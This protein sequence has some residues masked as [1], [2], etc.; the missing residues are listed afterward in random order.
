MP[1]ITPGI[2]GVDQLR[3][4][5]GSPTADP[6]EAAAVSDEELK[7]LIERKSQMV[8]RTVLNRLEK[9]LLENTPPSSTHVIDGETI[10]LDEG[11]NFAV[12]PIP[13]GYYPMTFESAENGAQI[14]TFDSSI[15]PHTV[16]YFERRRFKFRGS[17]VY[18]I[19]KTTNKITLYLPVKEKINQTVGADVI[20]Q[21]N[22]QIKEAAIQMVQ[23]KAQV[24]NDLEQSD[25]DQ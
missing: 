7:N 19:P 21:A 14:F 5:I 25:L 10:Q 17:R 2:I 20:Q 9:R 1:S 4:E 23:K 6:R 8:E 18:V 24:G 11:D 22:L 3:S 12:G 13:D 15:E 16:G